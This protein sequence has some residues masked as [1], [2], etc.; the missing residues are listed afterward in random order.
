MSDE[1]IC[2]ASRM[3]WL[4]P[5]D[6]VA[7][8]RASVRYCRPTLCRKCSRE[9]TS[10]R[11][12][13]AILASFSLNSRLSRNASSSVIGSAV[14]SEMFSPPTVTASTSGRR[15]APRQ[16]GQAVSAMQDSIDARMA[17]LCVS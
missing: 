16:S 10:R 15:R 11:M 14:Y 8:E 13:S 4:S 2:V 7:A 12:L 5:P 6:S 17:S 3:R 1:P 9:R